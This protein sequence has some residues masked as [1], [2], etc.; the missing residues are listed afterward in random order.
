MFAYPLAVANDNQIRNRDWQSQILQLIPNP[1][2]GARFL[3]LN[4]PLDT[5]DLLFLLALSYDDRSIYVNTRKVSAGEKN[6][7]LDAESGA[8]DHVLEHR[9]GRFILLK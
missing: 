9:D 6:V 4:D 1:K 8:Y 5:Y 2:P 7:V 3:I